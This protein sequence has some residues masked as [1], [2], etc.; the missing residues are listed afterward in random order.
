MFYLRYVHLVYLFSFALTLIFIQQNPAK[1]ENFF[2]LF[3]NHSEPKQRL[4][5]VE[6]KIYKPQKKITIRVSAQK[7]KAENAKRVL[8]IGDF[9]AS[10]VANELNFFFNDNRDVLIINNSVPSSGLIRTDY[11]SWQK[12]I[13]KLIY[14][15]KP[16]A[17]VIVIGANDNQPITTPNGIISTTQPE[18]I[19]IYKQRI[20]EIATSLHNSGKPWIWIGQPSFKNNNLMQKMK[21]F[22]DLYKNATE[23]ESGYFLD[24]WNDFVD[25]Q[26]QFSFS[27]CDINGKTVMLRTNDGINFTP[28]GKKKIAFYLRKKLETVL[29][30]GSFSDGNTHSTDLNTS[31]PTQEPNYVKR[32]HPMSL[33]DMAQQNTRLLDKTDSTMIKKSLSLPNGNKINRADNF[34]FP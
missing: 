30:F 9:V 16:D 26:G 31:K 24:I 19:A 20:A 18:W 3:F 7:L 10:V 1:A 22:N 27:G 5:I 29:N 28:E 32:M 11:Y 17:I 8:I 25:T 23:V 2:K 21:S 34:F 33:D 6:Q 12:N 15:H 13:S 14:T 4:Q